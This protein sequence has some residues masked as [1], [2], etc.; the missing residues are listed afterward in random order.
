MAYSD[1][2]N[3]RI[4]LGNPS[5]SDLSPKLLALCQRRADAFI[6]GNLRH[7]YTVPFTVVPKQVETWSESLTMFEVL[8]SPDFRMRYPVDTAMTNDARDKAVQEIVAA[9]RRKIRLVGT[10]PF[11]VTKSSTANY[12]RAFGLDEPEDWAVD[13]DQLKD[14]KA[15]RD[16]GSGSGG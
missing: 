3:V 10:D 11:D 1:P 2:S 8:K 6:D 12:H 16:K 15:K 14:L 4:L 7:L 13:P 5:D 9:A